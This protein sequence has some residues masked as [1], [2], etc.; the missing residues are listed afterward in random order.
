MSLIN[1][2]NYRENES[3]AN[4]PNLLIPNSLQNKNIVGD[5]IKKVSSTMHS[6]FILYLK[7]LHIQILCLYLNNTI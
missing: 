2:N 4:I 3:L 7:Q 1:D 6:N 5:T